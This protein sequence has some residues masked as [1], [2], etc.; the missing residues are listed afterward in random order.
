MSIPL[1]AASE[2][3]GTLD[4]ERRARIHQLEF[5]RIWENGIDSRLVVELAEKLDRAE[6]VENA[7]TRELAEARAKLRAE[8]ASTPLAQHHVTVEGAV[9]RLVAVP[10][11]D[12]WA[13]F[14][15]HE[16][17]SISDND[18]GATIRLWSG[19]EGASAAPVTI[20]T[21]WSTLQVLESLRGGA[22]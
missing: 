19:S 4:A 3:R 9:Q 15:L 17:H 1:K 8:A 14:W 21:A 6:M 5:Y 18:R 12:G 20:R 16:L 22:S 13:S 7:L 11:A 10:V 2:W